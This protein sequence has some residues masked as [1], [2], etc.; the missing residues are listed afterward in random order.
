MDT[1]LARAKD[2]EVT[3]TELRAFTLLQRAS[4]APATI[5]HLEPTQAFKY[6]LERFPP[7]GP[8]TTRRSRR[9]TR[10]AEVTTTT[11]GLTQSWRRPHGTGA[12]FTKSWPSAERL[13]LLQ[14]IYKRKG[15]PPLNG[16]YLGYDLST[17]PGAFLKAPFVE[18]V[19]FEDADGAREVI[20]GWT[21][22]NTDF[23]GSD[24]FLVRDRRVVDYF[25]KMFE[26]FERLTTPSNLRGAA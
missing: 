8:S 20:F 4:Q 1:L 6:V 14:N 25:L 23:F 10:Q 22:T 24:C 19:V 7:F 11:L 18:F 13:R 15:E 2:S 5:T 26:R 21:T 16:S 12:S 3:L 9:R 17:Q